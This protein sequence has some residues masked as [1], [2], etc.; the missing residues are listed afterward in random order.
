VGI[1]AKKGVKTASRIDPIIHT[2]PKIYKT[3]DGDWT[4]HT[5][6]AEKDEKNQPK[7]Y[8]KKL[9]N[10]NLGNIPPDLVR[11]NPKNK[12]PLRT[13]YEEISAGAVLPGG[14]TIDY[15]IQTTVL[16]LPALRRLRFPIN[17]EEPSRVPQERNDAARTALAAL[18]IAAIYHS[19]ETGFDLR[20][21]CLLIPE[22]KP[23]FQLVNNDGEIET[24][25]LTADEAD[26]IFEIASLKA[27]AENLP[28]W[29]VDPISLKPNKK[30]I[31]T[32][33]ESRRAESLEEDYES[34]E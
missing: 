21:R 26:K 11:Y 28:D 34:E 2:N 3:R 10:L 22:G 1:N 17:G 14:V 19:W 4:A 8:E 13:M 20:S 30:L 29:L 16:S 9:S 31:G 18:A 23:D 5:E 12:R 7:R 6:N 27:K 25:A 24:F 33:K 15:A 32:I